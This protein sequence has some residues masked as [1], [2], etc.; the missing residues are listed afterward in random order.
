MGTWE[1]SS[2]RELADELVRIFP[3]FSEHWDE[4]ESLGYDG[5]HTLHTVFLTFAA[6]SHELLHNA[7]P[8]Q[9]EE[10]CTIVNSFVER[11]GNFE[12]AVSTCFLEHASQLGVRKIIKPLLSAEARREV[13]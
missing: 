7:E 10:F 3:P 6:K 9:L 2:P 1:I 11:G 13:R 8:K 12:N 5:D 4:G